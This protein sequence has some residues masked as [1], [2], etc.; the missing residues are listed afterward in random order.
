MN[1]KLITI[2]SIGPIIRKIKFQ[3]KTISLCHGVFDILHVG[4]IKHLKEASKASDVLIV[5]IT[6]DRYIKKGLGRPY[7]NDNLRAELLSSLSY[8][9]YIIISN[10]F[11][12][13]RSIKKNSTRFLF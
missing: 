2:E 3:K 11:T 6:G 7:F 13:T 8:V 1:K 9:D 4:H 5:S 10:E 12:G